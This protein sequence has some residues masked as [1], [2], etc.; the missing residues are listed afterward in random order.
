MWLV[1]DSC[2]TGIAGLISQEDESKTVSNAVFYSAKLNSAQWNP[3]HEI[4]M[5]AGIETMLRYKDILQGIH[6]KWIIDQIKG[7]CLYVKLNGWKR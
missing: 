7:I 4:E 6:F 3:V 2:A 1:T 5:F